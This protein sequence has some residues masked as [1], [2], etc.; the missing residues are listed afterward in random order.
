MSQ[1][2]ILDRFV[3]DD[4]RAALGKAVIGREIIVLDQTGSTNDAILQIATPNSSEGLVLFA[5]YQTAGR[6]QRG[7][8]WESAAAKG[9][10]F[11]ILLRPRIEIHR[12]PL[13]TAWA[14]ET[15]SEVIEN[16]FSLKTTV[17][18]P[19]D[20]QIDRR[21]VAGVLVEMRAREKALHSAIVGIG[22]NVNQ[23]LE[24][25]PK[26]LRARAVSLAIALGRQ[27]DRQNLAIAVLHSLDRSYRERFA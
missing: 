26:E 21:K 22:I 1:T 3:A 17:K 23:A 4:V 7:N 8:R 25:F 14:A 12:S 9:L 24:D 18:L 19:N 10:W 11:S 16:E 13:L 5:E 6:G 2:E 27:V 20:V 15:I